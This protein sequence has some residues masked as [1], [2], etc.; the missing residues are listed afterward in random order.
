MRLFEIL[1]RVLE[2][3]YI[4]IVSDGDDA[5]EYRAAHNKAPGEDARALSFLHGV[6]LSCQHTLVCLRVSGD[7]HR[8]CEHL[9]PGLEPHDVAEDDIGGRDCHKGTVAHDPRMRV[10]RHRELPHRI[11]CPHLKKGRDKD[12]RNY[13]EKKG[14]V[15]EAFEYDEEHRHNSPDH[16]EK[17]KQIIGYYAK[18]AL[19]VSVLGYIPLSLCGEAHRLICRQPPGQ[20]GIYGFFCCHKALPLPRGSM[21]CRAGETIKIIHTI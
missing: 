5:D 17:G 3:M 13:Y 20:R 9:I 4:V 18:I 2:L 11:F 8:V 12:V 15:S 6:R 1:R 10:G 14:Q 7:N 16:I 21:S 19:S